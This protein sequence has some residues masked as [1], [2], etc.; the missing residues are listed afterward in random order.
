LS[1]WVEWLERSHVVSRSGFDFLIEFDLKIWYSQLPCLTFSTK[2]ARHL[3][4]L[5][6]SL[7]G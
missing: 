5:S 7:S 3:M 4:G 2:G 6:L 1:T